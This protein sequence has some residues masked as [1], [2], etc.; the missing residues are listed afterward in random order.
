MSGSSTYYNSCFHAISHP[1]V[2]L[3]CEIVSEI[4]ILL[5]LFANVTGAPPIQRTAISIDA[6]GLANSMLVL[7]WTD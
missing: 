2:Y 6:A 3:T 4:E 5:I 7:R 1:S